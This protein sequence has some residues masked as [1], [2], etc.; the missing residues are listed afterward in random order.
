MACGRLEVWSQVLQVYAHGTEAA[1]KLAG[2]TCR[3]LTAWRDALGDRGSPASLGL[4]DA[5]L[6]SVPGWGCDLHVGVSVL[7]EKNPGLF[8]GV[9]NEVSVHVV[10]FLHQ[11]DS[12]Q[13]ELPP[14][15]W[16]GLFPQPQVTGRL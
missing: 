11:Q 12:A 5:A 1:G 15:Q 3:T 10:S 8:L 14:S 4:A 2:L 16:F 7:L 13:P 6:G 9:F